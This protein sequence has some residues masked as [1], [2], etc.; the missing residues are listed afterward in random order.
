MPQRLTRFLLSP[1]CGFALVLIMWASLAAGGFMLVLTI[2]AVPVTVFAVGANLSYHRRLRWRA[3]LEHLATDMS[4]CLACQQHGALWEAPDGHMF[5][6][7]TR[8]RESAPRPA[9]WRLIA[10][11]DRL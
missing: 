6:L 8:H 1:W 5:L 4:G 2:L 11:A 3:L 9:H 10:P 7:C